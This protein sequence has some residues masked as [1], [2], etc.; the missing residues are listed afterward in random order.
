MSTSERQHR[1][2]GL[3]RKHERRDWGG[4]DMYWGK[5]MGILGEGCWGWSCQ[6]RGNGEGQ[7]G[8]LWMWW[9]R[10]WLRLKWRRRMQT[11]GATG[12]WKSAV[13]TPD[14]KK[15]KEEEEKEDCAR[16]NWPNHHLFELLQSGKCY[17]SVKAKTTRFRN[18]FYLEVMG[19]MN[20]EV[21]S[22]SNWIP[23]V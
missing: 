14:G 2:D 4:V 7:K 11:I 10:T 17:R 19:Y 22:S 6:E 16:C 13:A 12:D 3:E 23:V 1:W 9:K 18:S 8:G 15:S 20:G 5:M 21:G